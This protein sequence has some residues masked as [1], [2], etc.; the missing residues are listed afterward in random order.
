MLERLPMLYYNLGPAGDRPFPAWAA[1][2]E[3]RALLHDRPAVLGL[4]EAVGWPLPQIDGYR[5]IRNLGRPGRANIAAY[6]RADLKAPRWRM[7]WHD[8]RQTWSRTQ[9]PGTHPPRSWLEMQ[10]EGVQVIVGHQP[11]KFTDNVIASQQE[12][13]NLLRTRMGPWTRP[14][15]KWV[16]GKKREL[17]RPRVVLADFNRRAHEEGPGPTP[18]AER[19]G[20][21]VVGARIDCAVVRNGKAAQVCYIGQPAGVRLMSDHPEAL[22]FTLVVDRG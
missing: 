14:T 7:R 13:I 4:S 5:L 22:S 20:G 21:E 8:L 6:V 1:R 16:V 11:P 17:A 15:W 2:R 3:I 12:G 19:I 10:V 18:L 9:H